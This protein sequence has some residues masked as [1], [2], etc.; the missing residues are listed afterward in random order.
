PSSSPTRSRRTFKGEL[1]EAET[2]QQLRLRNT[3]GGPSALVV[4]LGQHYVELADLALGGSRRCRLLQ[5]ARRQRIVGGG[6]PRLEVE[7]PLQV[8]DGLPGLLQP[9]GRPLALA[10]GVELL[11]EVPEVPR[12]RRE[13]ADAHRVVGG[14]IILGVLARLG[15]AAAADVL[16]VLGEGVVPEVAGAAIAGGITESHALEGAR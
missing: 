10:G 3:V 5:Q 7:Q 11:G 9:L 12:R 16:H 14:N 2:L 6:E 1:L 4:V 8:P 15:L 13:Q